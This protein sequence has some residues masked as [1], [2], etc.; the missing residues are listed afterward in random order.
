MDGLARSVD[1]PPLSEQ[2]PAAVDRGESPGY[3]L[4]PEFMA[5]ITFNASQMLGGLIAA[6]PVDWTPVMAAKVAVEM[7]VAVANEVR[8]YRIV[9]NKA[10]RMEQGSDG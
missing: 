10:V 8:M 4:G 5:A 2:T 3:P 1:G 6:T 7:A 9:D